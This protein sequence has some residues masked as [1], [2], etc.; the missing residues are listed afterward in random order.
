MSNIILL[1][2]AYLAPVQYYT[3]F[4]V[5]DKVIIEAHENF[6]KQTYRNRCKIYGANGELTLTIPVKKINTKT[7]IK[8][9]LIDYD[10]NWRKLHW[11][12]IESAYNSSPFFE[13]YA[14]DFLPLF[15]KKFNFL[16]DLNTEL[17]SMILSILDVNHKLNFTDKYVNSDGDIDDMRESIH[18]KKKI[19]D[20]Q[21][22]IIKY[23]Q[24]FQQKTGFI[25]NLSIIDLLFNEGPN[26][27]EILNLS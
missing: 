1:S 22:K 16:F 9:L 14:D 23:T 7:K 12:S 2:T 6:I 5:Y 24:V 3:K 20:Q 18:P 25:P 11:K 8:E 19:E 15:T 4:L 13:Y 21:F 26:A 27:T 10:T 17:L